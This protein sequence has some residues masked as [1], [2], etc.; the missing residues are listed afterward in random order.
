MTTT[1]KTADPPREELRHRDAALPDPQP[2]FAWARDGEAG[3]ADLDRD[4]DTSAHDLES[5]AAAFCAMVE[6]AAWRRR[7]IGPRLDHGAW[8]AE[9]DS[10]FAST[11]SGPLVYWFTRHM[12]E[13][14]AR[15]AYRI[16]MEDP[17]YAGPGETRPRPAAGLIEEL[18]ATL[19]NAL[20]HHGDAMPDAD[21]AS[22]WALVERAK[23]VAGVA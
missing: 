13:A 16:G 23:R 17:T 15:R 7:E 4:P 20:L 8:D 11:D 18:A 3:P 19:E 6:H 22:R 2:F 9:L 5:E 1:T 14:E 21:R 12:D 10:T